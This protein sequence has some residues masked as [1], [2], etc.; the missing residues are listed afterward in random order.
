M[1]ELTLSMSLAPQCQDRGILSALRGL[2]TLSEDA[3][4][5]RILKKSI[6]TIIK[7]RLSNIGAI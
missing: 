7:V 3:A 5:E 1:F 4:N 6:Q 2:S